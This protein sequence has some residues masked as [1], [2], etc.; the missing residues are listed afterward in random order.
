MKIVLNVNVC[1][2]TVPSNSSTK[3]NVS[4][5][6]SISTIAFGLRSFNENESFITTSCTSSA[7]AICNETTLPI[8]YSHKLSL[9]ILLYLKSDN[10]VKFGTFV[11]AVNFIV[12][13]FVSSESLNDT[14][15]VI[16][17]LQLTQTQ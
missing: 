15:Y 13:G 14:L 6:Y 5:M 16:N 10:T 11:F 4:G 17:G 1:V 2:C 8:W 3:D 9:S 12:V 7:A